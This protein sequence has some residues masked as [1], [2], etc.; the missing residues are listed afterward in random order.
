MTIPGTPTSSQSPAWRGWL[1][2][3]WCF[4]L[5]LLAV[6]LIT[7]SLYIGRLGFYWDDW[8]GVFL[9]RFTNLRAYWDFYLSDRPFSAWTYM[10]FM[11]LLGAVP[12][13]W[14][15]FTL[16]VRWFS[17]LMFCR[18]LSD[19]WPGKRWQ[20]GW[21]GL[22]LAIYPGFSQQ[23]ISVA[24]SQHF[25]TAA[26][27]TLSLALMT[28]AVRQPARAAWLTGLALICS[29]VH[30]LTMEYFVGLELLRPLLLW[31]MLHQPGEKPLLTLRKTFLR[32]LP[33]LLPLVGF[34]YYRF[35]LYYQITPGDA[36]PPLLLQTLLQTPAEGLL[37]LGNLALQDG[38]HVLLF[39]WTN[40][41]LPDTIDLAVK[42]TLF[43]WG[44]GLIVAA[45]TAWYASQP[46]TIKSAEDKSAAKNGFLWQALLVGLA[47]I[48]LGGLP[49]WSTDRQILVGLWSDR[50]T[51]APMFGAVLIV[52]ALVDWLGGMGNLPRKSVFLAFLL[53]ISVAAHLRTL[54]KYG[55]H[56]ELARNY[57]WQLSWR[58]PSL[59]PGTA[60]LAPELPF[61]YSSD[62]SLGFALNSIYAGELDKTQMDYWWIDALRY[63]GGPIIR[64]LQPDIPLHYDLRNIT[65]DGN[66]SQSIVVSYN[67]ARGCLRVLDPLYRY[68]PNPPLSEQEQQLWTVASEAD[69]ILDE[70]SPGENALRQIFGPEPAHGWC[71]YF[72]K[73]DLARQM[74][75]W[76]QVGKLGD[77]AA[78]LG[79]NPKNGTE[80]VPF[81]EGYAHLGAWQTAA[82][83]TVDA[84]AQT[85]NLR[86]LLCTTWKRIENETP[87]SAEREAAL[88]TVRDAVGCR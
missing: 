56:W 53:A 30:M 19:V 36:N 83:L 87:P 11:P 63:R 81:I 69:E 18:A 85:A 17:V 77:Q 10:V 3:A 61:S 70:P 51:L 7:Y 54:N 49:V 44:L 38:I 39:A 71:Y 15:L 13:H 8:Q 1:K 2:Q 14:Q 21:V 45:G 4:P 57:F 22:L 58:A 65:F 9:S 31:L 64:D 80:R 78:E 82:N 60:V 6:M 88:E 76:Q 59:K 37:R 16:L 74:K 84:N 12:L 32:W 55:E 79:F 43:S 29:L 25:L 42:Q 52:V 41:I 75:D 67:N 68:M 24:Y 48:L 34:A 28:A 40:T 20:I 47:G 35:G 86:G 5:V 72:E 23:A 33:Y 73:A 62:Y 46:E 26:L 66:T 27:F 50:F